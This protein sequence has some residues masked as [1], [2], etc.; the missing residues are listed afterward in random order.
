MLIFSKYVK[1][2]CKSVLDKYILSTKL[3]IFCSE[4]L[5]I[6]CDFTT[7]N[8]IEQNKNYGQ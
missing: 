7:L 5:E 1:K 8:T 2:I 6:T 4:Q 3:K